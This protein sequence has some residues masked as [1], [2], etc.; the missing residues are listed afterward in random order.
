MFPHSPH[1][2]LLFQVSLNIPVNLPNPS[3]TFHA[4]ILLVFFNLCIFLC[5]RSYPVHGTV[6]MHGRFSETS[7]LVSE[8]LAQMRL[9]STNPL[10]AF[11]V[12]TC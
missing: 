2:L 9:F 7:V 1:V 10:R 3:R 8:L 11:A 6:R 5:L 4:Y 12:H